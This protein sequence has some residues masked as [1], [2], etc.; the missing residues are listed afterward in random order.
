MKDSSVAILSSKSSST[1]LDEAFEEI[2]AMAEEELWVSVEFIYG[3]NSFWGKTPDE[4]MSEDEITGIIDVGD[5]QD[6]IYKIISLTHE[7]GH[8]IHDRDKHFKNAKETMFSESIAWFLGYKWCAHRGFVIDM[9]EYKQ[10]MS[11]CL[12]MYME[13]E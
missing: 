11:K 7:I 10:M 1:E 12:R 8:A 9:D 6:T 2:I 3:S 5:D 4:E 13:M